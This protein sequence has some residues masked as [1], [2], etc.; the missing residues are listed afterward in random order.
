ML[1]VFAILDRPA[2]AIESPATEDHESRRWLDGW[3]DFIEHR[4]G[5]GRTLIT[6]NLSR[7][8]FAKRF[9][10]RI[11]SRLNACARAV[12]IKGESRRTNG[13]GF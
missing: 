10:A 8:D 11:I 2:D 13:G 5:I 12:E 1:W 6:S 3:G 9:D 4:Q 7:E